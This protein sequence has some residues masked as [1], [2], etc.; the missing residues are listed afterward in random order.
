M[1][2]TFILKM[3]KL[4]SYINLANMRIFEPIGYQLRLNF[5]LDKYSAHLKR[6]HILNIPLE[7]SSYQ[8]NIFSLIFQVLNYRNST[9]V[10]ALQLVIE[11]SSTI[12]ALDQTYVDDIY[13]GPVE[14]DHLEHSEI[15]KIK[16]RY[17]KDIQEKVKEI[18]INELD[19]ENIND[20]Y[21]GNKNINIMR[22]NFLVR[23]F[24]NLL[25]RHH[26]V[27]KKKGH[28]KFIIFILL[29]IQSVRFM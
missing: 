23:F 4:T 2:G 27:N 15:Y 29:G 5:L 10:Y 28:Y 1:F 24:G 18:R 22:Q 12:A 14:R 21:L 25:Y 3:N 13:L 26:L 7:E 9:T 17:L 19:L 8:K 11:R 16:Q 20:I 6:K